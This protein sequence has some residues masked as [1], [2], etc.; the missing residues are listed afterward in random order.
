MMLLFVGDMLGRLGFPNYLE[1]GPNP[2]GHKRT[3]DSMDLID[4]I[5]LKCG[6]SLKFPYNQQAT[7]TVFWPQPLHIH[8]C[9]Y[10]YIYIYIFTYICIYIYIYG[11]ALHPGCGRVR[12]VGA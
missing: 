7:H 6:L 4:F 12:S 1:P 3:T 5:D 10:I 9:I 2:T 11:L 8:M